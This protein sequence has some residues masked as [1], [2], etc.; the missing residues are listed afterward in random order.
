MKRRASRALLL[1]PWFLAVASPLA[2]GQTVNDGRAVASAGATAR[3]ADGGGQTGGTATATAGAGGTAGTGGTGIDCCVTQPAP[4]CPPTPPRNGSSCISP[5]TCSYPAGRPNCPMTTASCSAAG[6]SAAT[7]W[8]VV[9]PI[10]EVPLPSCPA[11][12]PTLGT[13]CPEGGALAFVGYGCSYLTAACTN[14]RVYCSPPNE[15][16]SPW[17]WSGAMCLDPSVGQGG[18]GDAGGGGAGGQGGVAGAP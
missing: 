10:C 6:G 1:A 4:V 18:A 3:G 12:Q 7:L 9:D 16:T 2:C 17:T 11:Q 15:P 5:Q 13:T 8:N 14:Y